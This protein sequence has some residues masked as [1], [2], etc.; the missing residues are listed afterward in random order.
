MVKRDK[1]FSVLS[2]KLKTLYKKVKQWMW[3]SQ[4]SIP[5]DP[6]AIVVHEV[7]G[8]ASEAPQNSQSEAMAASFDSHTCTVTLLTPFS[9]ISGYQLSGK[10][11]RGENNKLNHE[12]KL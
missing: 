1:N 5:S 8:V 6:Q 12:E 7:W 10:K 3:K 9:S 2:S 11:R 4:P